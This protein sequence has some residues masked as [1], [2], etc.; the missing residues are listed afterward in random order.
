MSALLFSLKIANSM[1]LAL[2]LMAVSHSMDAG[3]YWLASLCG[4]AALG[5]VFSLCSLCDVTSKK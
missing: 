2:C 1:G 3:Q 4:L 5:S